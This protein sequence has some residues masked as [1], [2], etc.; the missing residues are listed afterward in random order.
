MS[1]ELLLMPKLF[2]VANFGMTGLCVAYP[3]PGSSRG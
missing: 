3:P 1:D 2:R